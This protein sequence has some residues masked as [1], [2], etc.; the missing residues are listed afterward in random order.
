MGKTIYAFIY[1]VQGN[2]I[3]VV[4]FDTEEEVAA[5]MGK[6]FSCLHSGYN[7]IAEYNAKSGSALELREADLHEAEEVF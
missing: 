3:D 5:F 1:I 2:I 6:Y 7:T 4:A